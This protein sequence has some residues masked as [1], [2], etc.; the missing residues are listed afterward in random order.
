M[1]ADCEDLFQEV[2]AGVLGLRSVVQVADCG[3]VWDPRSWATDATD[4]GGSHVV[5]E[6]KAGFAEE[7]QDGVQRTFVANGEIAG[8]PY[9]CGCETFRVTRVAVYEGGFLSSFV[10]K[11]FP[12]VGFER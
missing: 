6:T 8:T 2:G 1:P 4:G 10:Y 9:I 7:V 5:E 11:L 3:L 12:R